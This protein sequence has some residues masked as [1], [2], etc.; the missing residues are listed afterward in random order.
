MDGDAKK[1]AGKI[2]RG[3]FEKK[4]Q[5]RKLYRGPARR[6]DFSFGF[7]AKCNGAQAQ[8]AQQW[9][10]AGLSRRAVYEN[11][12]ETGF[13]PNYRRGRGNQILGETAMAGP[14]LGVLS[15]SGKKAD[16]RKIGCL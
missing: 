13:G 5:F 9:L 10:N 3:Q 6:L 8:I 15:I 14:A 2:V 12:A 11:A 4:K 16:E 1:C 7:D